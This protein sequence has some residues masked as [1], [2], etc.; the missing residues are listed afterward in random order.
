MLDPCICK[1]TQ[2][3][4]GLSGAGPFPTP[5]GGFSPL[6]GVPLTPSPGQG[7]AL[8]PAHRCGALLRSNTHRGILTDDAC[9]QAQPSSCDFAAQLGLFLLLL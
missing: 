3:Y 4:L 5:C 1:T 7:S 6:R 8:M 2:R 9:P